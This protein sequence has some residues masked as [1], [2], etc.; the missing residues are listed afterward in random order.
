[1]PP[2]IIAC[3]CACQHG[4]GFAGPGHGPTAG[5]PAQYFAAAGASPTPAS[6]VA[7]APTPAAVPAGGISFSVQ[8]PAAGE[9][10]DPDGEPGP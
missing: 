5:W 2:I 9:R 1:M 7:P 4:A 10:L 6:T 8:A 3:G